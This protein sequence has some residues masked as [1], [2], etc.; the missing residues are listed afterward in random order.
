MGPARR[1][2]PVQP[3]PLEREAQ[4]QRE[5]FGHIALPRMRRADPL[6]DAGAFRDAAAHIGEADTAQERV[7]FEAEKQKGVT[8]VAMPF[9]RVA[10]EAAAEGGARQ[11]VLA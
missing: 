11:R 9:E 1:F 4:S 3:Q 5:A 7:V 2:D 6:A 10:R 8:L